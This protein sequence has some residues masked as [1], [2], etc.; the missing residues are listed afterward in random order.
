MAGGSAPLSTVLGTS[1]IEGTLHNRNPKPTTTE[2]RQLSYTLHTHLSR[3][4]ARVGPW[5]R[6]CAEGALVPLE[7]KLLVKHPKD[8]Q[9]NPKHL[10]LLSID[11]TLSYP[12]T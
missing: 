6:K 3:R 10:Y 7:H 12:P 11:M 4:S 5:H 2:N 1:R 9:A 8:P